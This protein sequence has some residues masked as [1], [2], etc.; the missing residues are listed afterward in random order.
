[1]RIVAISIEPVILDFHEY[2]AQ[3]EHDIIERD[4]TVFLTARI[5]AHRTT[6]LMQRSERR[7]YGAIQRS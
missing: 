5:F 7:S 2:A 4:S 6:E 3:R 1:M